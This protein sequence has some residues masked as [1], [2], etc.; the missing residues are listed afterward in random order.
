[1]D[2]SVIDNS[3]DFTNKCTVGFSKLFFHLLQL[4]FRL[5]QFYLDESH[6]F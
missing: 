5:P 6:L 4:V 3:S 1:M 2:G